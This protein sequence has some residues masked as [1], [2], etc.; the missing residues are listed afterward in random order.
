M[1]HPRRAAVVAG[2]VVSAEV[3]TCDF[4]HTPLV[5]K[6]R[7]TKLE[8][9]KRFR[10]RRYCNAVCSRTHR[11]AT[12]ESVDSTC[13]RPGCEASLAGMRAG[14]RFCSRSCAVRTRNAN[15]SSKRGGN[16]KTAPKARKASEPVRTPSKALEA[17]VASN[18]GLGPL[19]P[20]AFTSPAPKRHDLIAERES[21]VTRPEPSRDEI[22]ALLKACLTLH[23]PMLECWEEAAQ[24]ALPV[25]RVPRAGTGRARWQA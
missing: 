11:A 18:Y 20:F 10:A 2:P 25:R 4:C 5:R 7:K 1:V 8:E 16:P 24:A 19:Q 23:E 3:R 22:L 9:P 15:T 21:G 6:K 14:A 17:N 12:K 13:E